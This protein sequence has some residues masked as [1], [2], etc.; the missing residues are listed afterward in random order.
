MILVFCTNPTLVLR[1]SDQSSSEYLPRRFKKII[2]IQV[3]KKKTRFLVKPWDFADRRTFWPTNF[4]ELIWQL[5][6]QPKSNHFSDF[7]PWTF[8]GFK[9]SEFCHI[10]KSGEMLHQI[11]LNYFLID[12]F[13]PIKVR[14]KQLFFRL[15]RTKL[16]S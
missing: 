15:T 13:S 9:N 2:E 14:Q 10:E 7:P 16:N 11:R 12:N 3:T 5:L 8:V 4:S 6:N 1:F